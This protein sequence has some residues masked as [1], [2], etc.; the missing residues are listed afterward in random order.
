MVKCVPT[1]GPGCAISLQQMTAK[2]FACSILLR[3][4]NTGLAQLA[5]CLPG[6]REVL[7]KTRS[8]GTNLQP[9]SQGWRQEDGVQ[10]H[11]QL[12]SEFKTSLSYMTLCKKEMKGG[13]AKRITDL[14][15]F[16]KV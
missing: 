16:C 14:R 11:H 2:Y 3:M 7:K 1:T 12:H 5:E 6:I 9:S 4:F 13:M 8:G 10:A 15:E